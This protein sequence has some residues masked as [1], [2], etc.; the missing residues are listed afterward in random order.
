MHC[1]ES[2]AERKKKPISI[3]RHIFSIQPTFF[4]MIQVLSVQSF[5]KK[6][7][8][9]H[10]YGNIRTEQINQNLEKRT[11]WKRFDLQSPNWWFADNAK[12]HFRMWICDICPF[13]PSTK[14][15]CFV[16]VNH[17]S[18]MQLL[19]KGQKKIILL[20]SSL[21]MKKNFE[22]IKF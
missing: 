16:I 10:W 7:Q 1:E 12:P 21:E 4:L 5:D 6:E 8:T 2:K 11:F 22:E 19:K 17:S 13:L 15:L 9:F 18:K 3:C 14:V 20:F